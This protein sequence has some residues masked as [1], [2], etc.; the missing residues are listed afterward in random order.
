M[1]GNDYWIIREIREKP[2]AEQI[3]ELHRLFE[4]FSRRGW[5]RGEIPEGGWNVGYSDWPSAEEVE[6]DLMGKR[7]FYGAIRNICGTNLPKNFEEVYARFQRNAEQ[8]MKLSNM[9]DDERRNLPTHNFF[10]YFDDFDFHVKL[11]AAE[12]CWENGTRLADITFTPDFVARGGFADIYKAV[13]KDGKNYALKVFH[14]HQQLN[15]FHQESRGRVVHGIFKN[16]WNAREIVS[17]NP[18]AALRALPDSEWYLMDFAPGISVDEMIKQNPDAFLDRRAVHAMQVYARMLEDLHFKGFT[19]GDN[20]WSSVIV[21]DGSV[22]ICDYDTVS[23]PDS[24][25]PALTTPVY[26]SRE[27]LTYSAINQLSDLES[28]ALMIDH[29]FNG[30]TMNEGVDQWEFGKIRNDEA[31]QNKK[32]HPAER[33]KKMPK[34]LAGVVSG[35]LNYPRDESLVARDFV[36]AIK[37]DYKI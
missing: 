35:V 34:N 5:N 32:T 16:L 26:S 22:K 4:V 30:E 6:K 2:E 37:E 25:L 15:R 33:F 9:K 21:N 8:M 7:G 11:I 28:F 29:L 13:G 20:K 19:F 3:P 14:M 12:R 17:Q 23:T 31:K 10:P 18:F 36:S 24:E 1:D 27:H